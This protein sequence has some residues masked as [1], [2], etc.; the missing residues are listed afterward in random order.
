MHGGPL[1]Y[2]QPPQTRNREQLQAGLPNQSAQVKEESTIHILKN[3]V[4]LD[5]S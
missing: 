2:R 3:L 1:I 4:F 5:I